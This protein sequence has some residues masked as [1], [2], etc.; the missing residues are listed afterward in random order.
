M[1]SAEELRHV[2]VVEMEPVVFMVWTSFGVACTV[3]KALGKN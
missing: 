2:L 1:T 3:T